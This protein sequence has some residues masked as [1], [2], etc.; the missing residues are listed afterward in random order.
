MARNYGY[1]LYFTPILDT[2]VDLADISVHEAAG[3]GLA[4]G[5]FMDRTTL[6]PAAANVDQF[7]T[8]FGETFGIT[9]NKA[10]YTVTNAALATNVAT[11]TIGTNTLAVGSQLVV[12]NLPSPFASLNGTR[13]ITARDATTVSFALTGSN[14]SSASVVAG[15]ATGGTDLKLDGTDAPVRM[16]GIQS[17]PPSSDTSEETEVYWDDIAM[18]FEQGEAVSKSASLDMNG[19]IDFNSTAYK[20][21]RL[22]EKGNVSK[23]L[24]AKLALIG[25]R[26]YNE[27]YFGYGRFNSYSPD[28]AAGA[29]AKFTAG[30]KFFGPYGLNLHNG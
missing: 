29:T 27:T 4:V 30:F 1:G 18:G 5:G 25:P 21:L 3:T 14:I 12:A 7:G 10:T 8:G 16:L 24:M 15:T 2:F 26:G 19:K 17:G 23:G 11:L 6:L 20:L 13:V 22:L 28:N 9:L